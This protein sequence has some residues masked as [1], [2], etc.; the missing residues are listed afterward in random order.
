MQMQLNLGA[1][2]DIAS[3]SELSGVESRLGDAIRGG[4]RRA[5]PIR[6]PRTEGTTGDGTNLKT[7]SFGSPIIGSMWFIRS[8]TLFGNDDSTTVLNTLGAPLTAGLY[9]GASVMSPSLANLL[10]PGMRFPQFNL[11]D[12]GGLWVTAQETLFFITSTIPTSGQRIGM[13]LRYEEWHIA[14]VARLS[15]GRN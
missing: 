9:I 13:N 6:S 1:E 3:G 8:V 2:L 10:V 14:D 15:D 11:F 5:L 7:V 4:S 12:D